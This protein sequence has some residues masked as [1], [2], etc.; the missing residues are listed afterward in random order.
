MAQL[1]G[2]G[3]LRAVR[4]LLDDLAEDLK[5]GT[6]QPQQRDAA[7]ET[8]K[9][10]GRDP[11]Y[12]DPIFTKEG[13]EVLAKF[14]FDSSSDTTSRNALRVL[15]NALFLKSQTR[16]IFVDLGYEPKA[17]GKLKNDNRDDEFLISR[18]I[19]LT[20]YGTSVDLPKLIE[21]HQLADSITQNLSRHAARFSAQ[22]PTAAAAGPMEEMALAETL[23]LLF[24]V[25]NFAKKHITAFDGALPHIASIICSHPLPQT[26]TP[27]DSPF[28][29]LINA[30]LNLD[31]TTPTA[32]SALY[33]PTEPTLVANRLLHLL[34]LAMKSYTDESLDQSVSPLICALSVLYEH[35]PK[36]TT[37]TTPTSNGK[38]PDQDDAADVRA[39]VRSTLLPTEADRKTV[40][41]KTDTLPSRLL[42]NWTNALAPQFRS[43]VAHLYFD[44]SGKDAVRFIEN[45]GYG[46]ASGFLFENNI[47]IPEG[48]VQGSGRGE[49]SSSSSSRRE[50]NPITGQFLDEE[51]FPDL[52]E[53]TMEEKE[54]EAERLFVLFE[55]LKQTG[56][57][58]VQ[59]PV[60][61][62]MREGR[63]QDASLVR[64]FTG[65]RKAA[66]SEPEEEEEPEA[67]PVPKRGRPARSAGASA[68]ARLAAKAAKKPARG[69]PKSTAVSITI[70]RS[71]AAKPAKKD[72]TNG[73][74]PADE[75]EVEEI[76]DSA[77][78]ADTM[79]HMYFVKWKNYP[80]SDN[81][82]EP[83]KNLAGSLPL[84]RK[85]DAAKKKAEAAEAA[86]KAAAK[87]AAAPAAGEK[88]AT[89]GP[90]AKA[91]KAVKKA[92]GR[93]GRKRKARA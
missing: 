20:T 33:P 22:N 84:V 12:A 82:W 35:S 68:S 3:K 17:C 75:Y 39:A 89:R 6:L 32:Q 56:V 36:D 64:L 13:I 79:E 42:R 11:T 91:V 48:A 10:Y 47:S 31:L 19:L 44:L 50:V 57:V 46:Y 41:G 67:T 60:E 45:V 88:K 72:A 15:C 24:N 34:D 49:G 43:A 86:K 51:R 52:P 71:A 70:S 40:L 29:L 28:S 27:L 80:A 66:E 74:V 54:R 55:R 53:M 5:S 7:L 38:A 37:G 16:Q 73:E 30:L 65:K 4:K 61:M 21:Q 18:L 59:N 87:R 85:F 14:A 93:P 62:A 1:A 63:I 58:S 78:D 81:T 90:K 26:K 8:L 23:K 92:P 2:P 25:T 77:I 69:R 83:K 76:V 9:V